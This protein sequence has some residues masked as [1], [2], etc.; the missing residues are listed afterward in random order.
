[1]TEQA[2]FWDSC[3]FITYLIGDD[4]AR[5]FNDIVKYVDEAISRKRKIYFSTLTFAEIRQE[6]FK[7]NGPGSTL[8][9]FADLGSNFVPIEP[10]PNI[11]IAAG[12]LRSAKCVNPGDPYKPSVRSLA[13]P[14]AIIM[15]TCLFAREAFGLQDIVFHTMDEG[16]G[17]NWYGKSVPIIGFEKWYPET[18]RTK[19]VN[20]ICSLRRE[21]PIHPEP[22]LSGIIR[23]NFDTTRR[24][25]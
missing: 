7:T 2:I 16:K 13:T 25:R 24:Q 21:Q 17:K 8:D 14:D 11:M 15:M 19:R 6:F 5:H 3:V 4:S 1:M 12:E 9:F 20:D 23:P 10:N 22:S 18:T